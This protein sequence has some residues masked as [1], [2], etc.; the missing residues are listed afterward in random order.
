MPHTAWIERLVA[1][2][3]HQRSVD[4]LSLLSDHLLADM[5]LRRDQ[6]DALRLADAGGERSPVDGA[7]IRTSFRWRYSEGQPGLRGCG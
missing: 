3:S 6:L 5:G 7:P 1:Y 2:Y 4:K